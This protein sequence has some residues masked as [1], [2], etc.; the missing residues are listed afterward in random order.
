MPTISAPAGFGFSLGTWANTATRLVLL[1]TKYYNCTNGTT[2]SILASM[3]SCNGHIDRLIEL[4]TA[5][6][7]SPS[8]SGNARTACCCQLC[9]I[10]GFDVC[11]LAPYN[12]LHRHNHEIG[13]G[14]GNSTTARIRDQ[15]QSNLSSHFG[16]IFPAVRKHLVNLRGNAAWLIP[17]QV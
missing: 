2:W 13:Q 8:A 7:T 15:Q 17:C 4:A 10:D 1:L 5:T 3:P 14:T 11:Q 12:T 9:Q 6:L 16:D